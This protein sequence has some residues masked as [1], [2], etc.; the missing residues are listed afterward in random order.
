[1]GVRLYRVS[2]LAKRFSCVRG[3]ALGM[4][5]VPEVNRIRAVRLTSVCPHRGRQEE[6]AFP[7]AIRV[8]RVS[9]I[10]NRGISG[11]RLRRASNRSIRERETKTA[12]TGTA[13]SVF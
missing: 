6:R 4:L 10:Q 5:V 7:S 1:M 12:D 11:K 9:S 3:I 8:G 2:Q 13:D